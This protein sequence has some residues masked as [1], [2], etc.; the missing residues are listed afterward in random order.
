MCKSQLVKCPRCRTTNFLYTPYFKCYRNCHYVDEKDIF[1]QVNEV[2]EKQRE[3]VRK[4]IKHLFPSNTPAIEFPET[5]IYDGNP[6]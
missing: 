3:E 5:N 1:Y 4:I 2:E 6:D